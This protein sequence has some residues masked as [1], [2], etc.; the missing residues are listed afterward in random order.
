MPQ[1]VAIIAIIKPAPGKLERVG[2]LFDRLNPMFIQLT[3]VR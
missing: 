3:I 1:E 2:R